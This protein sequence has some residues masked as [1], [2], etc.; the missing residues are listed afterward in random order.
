MEERVGLMER[1]WGMIEERQDIEWGVIERGRLNHA[2]W[3]V[4]EAVV[5]SMGSWTGREPELH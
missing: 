1:W 3:A 2:G 5:C 4:L